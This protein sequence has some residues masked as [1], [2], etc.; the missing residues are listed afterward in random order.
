MATLQATKE[1][2]K[3]SGVEWIGDIPVGWKVGRVKNIFDISK[4]KI[5]GQAE[6]YQI[7]ALTL[8]G[9]KKRD[10]STNEGQVAASYDNYARLRQNDIVLN[11]MDLISGF[12][13]RQNG[14]GIISPAYTILRPRQD[15]EDTHYFEKF[16]Q[17]HYLQN[18]F[19]PFGKGVSYD[20]RWTL[21]DETLKN[22]PIA[23]PPEE[24][25]KEI[26]DFLDE[27][28]EKVDRVIEK[29]KKLIELLK[30]KRSSLITHAVTKGLDPNTKMKDS[31]VAWIG[32][33]PAGWV[34]RKLKR[35]S[36][37]KTGA[38]PS[39]LHP[40]YFEEGKIPWF[41]PGDINADI[42]LHESSRYITDIAVKAKK[43]KIFPSSTVFLVGIGASVGKSACIYKEASCNQQINAITFD[44]TIE[45]IYGAYLLKSLEIVIREIAPFATLPIMD[46]T[47]TG[48]LPFLIP[49]KETQK[50]IADFLD[51]KTGQI[52]KTIQKI[53]SQI[54]KLQEYR[55][56]LIYHAVTGK[57]EV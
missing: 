2:T 27:K 3:D 38:T 15:R 10:V 11:P 25:Q 28:T 17:Y 36:S 20:Y 29:K 4:E 43:A 51:E 5:A 26:A 23:I 32:E 55:P 22:F 46:Q 12:V 35:D 53:Q 16:F 48:E 1:K 42:F 7:Y 34:V 52:D 6:K 21:P 19:F 39:T 33:I 47:R 56:S 45:P 24:I 30:E 18:I 8:Q 57:I 49:P 41:S 54:N 31:G 13:A 9:L 44:K 40:E 37:I 14:E 50:Q